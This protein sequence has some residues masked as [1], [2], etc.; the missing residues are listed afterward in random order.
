[1][2][3]V[4]SVQLIQVKGGVCTKL[5]AGCAYEDCNNACKSYAKDVKLYAATCYFFNVCIC[6]MDRLPPGGVDHICDLPQGLCSNTC[7][8]ICCNARCK[9]LYPDKE[10]IGGCF[11]EY[12]HNFCMCKYVP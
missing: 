8:S 10:S 9:K 6:V 11:Q 7:D 4:V 1:M 5:V 12:D 3:L 2:V